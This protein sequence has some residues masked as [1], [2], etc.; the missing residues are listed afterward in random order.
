MDGPWNVPAALISVGSVQPFSKKV[1][2]PH[3]VRKKVECPQAVCSEGR[4]GI[5]RGANLIITHILIQSRILT[6][7]KSNEN[8]AIFSPSPPF[9]GEGAGGVRGRVVSNKSPVQ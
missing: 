7:L 8:P 5:A 1:E 6:P 4:N 3:A 9:R 2:C